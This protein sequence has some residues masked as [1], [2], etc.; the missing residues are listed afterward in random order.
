MKTTVTSSLVLLALTVACVVPLCANE[1]RYFETLV[2]LET[3]KK[4]EGRT[5]G[6]LEHA[7]FRCW[8]PPDAKTIRGLTFNPFYTKAV[9]QKHWQAA[10]R[11]WGFGILGSNLFG[12]K[13]GE[14]PRLIDAALE[15]VAKASGQ[16]ELAKAKL[17]PIGMSAGAGMSTQVASLMP[18]RVI[19]VGPVCLEVGPRDEAALAIP[20]L[21]VFGERDGSQYDKLLTKLPAARVGG[22]RFGIAVQWGRRHEFARANNLLMPLFDAAIR[23]RLGAPGEPLRPFPESAGWLGDVS[24]WRDS[25]AIIAPIAEF[26]GERANACWLPNETTARAWQAFVTREPVFELT[27]PPGLGDGQAFVLRRIGEPI[28]V[29]M[30][31]NEKRLALRGGVTVFAG[32]RK[33]GDLGRDGLEVTFEKPGIYPMFLQATLVDGGTALSRPNTVIVAGK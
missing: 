9:T 14:F 23:R 11:Q 24:N 29:A 7:P 28:E 19:A 5:E 16:P 27:S 8:L 18:D 4:K 13:K 17:C 15:E 10:C 26:P 30:K 32:E 3:P 25:V 31:W 33:L 22:A 12:V 21:T 20:M 6:G 1:G 2:R